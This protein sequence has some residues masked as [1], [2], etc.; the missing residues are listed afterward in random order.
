LANSEFTPH[1]TLLYG[2]HQAEE[3]PVEPV[4]WTVKEF[5]L[6]HSMRGHFRIG[7]WRLHA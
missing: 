4:G 5:A 7:S 1:V 2:E 6:I 3:N